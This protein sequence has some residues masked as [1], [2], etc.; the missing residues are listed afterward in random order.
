LKDCSQHYV[1]ILNC[2]LCPLPPKGVGILFCPVCVCLF[3]SN[4]N[5]DHNFWT[6]TYTYLLLWHACTSW[7]CTFWGVACQGHHSRSKVNFTTYLSNFNVD[8][9]FWTV[10][11]TYLILGM[12]IPLM[13]PHI[14]RGRMSRS[15]FK[16]R[17]QIN[18]DKTL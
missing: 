11:Y 8:H 6:I 1:Q 5:I 9:N 4:F 16:V 17:G 13:E 15:P 3:A 18:C 2:F 12:H 7:N 10:T 14:F